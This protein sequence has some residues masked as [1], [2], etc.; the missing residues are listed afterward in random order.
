[1]TPLRPDRLCEE[2]ELEYKVENRYVVQAVFGFFFAF[3]M[4][5]HVFV[6]AVAQGID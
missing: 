5:R 3:F 6:K 4:G 2:C 1:L